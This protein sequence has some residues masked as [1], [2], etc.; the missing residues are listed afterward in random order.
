[1]YNND[2]T[3]VQWVF[4]ESYQAILPHPENA[5]AANLPTLAKSVGDPAVCPTTCR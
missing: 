5:P 4:K 3:K 1:M 2:M